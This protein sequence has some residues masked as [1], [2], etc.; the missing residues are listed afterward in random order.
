MADGAGPVPAGIGKV[1]SSS[2]GQAACLQDFVQ[3]GGRAV[4]LLCP[5]R[6]TRAAVLDR[7]L[8]DLPNYATR[9]ANP[10]A[11]PLTLHRLLFQI[12]A[13]VGDGE[14]GKVLLRC[15]HEQAGP[16]G[17]AVLAVDDAHT[18]APDALAVLAQVPSPA[19]QEQPGRLLIL[20]GHPDLM[21][22]LSQ[23]GLAALHDPARVLVLRTEGAEDGGPGPAALMGIPGGL[24]DDL[25]GDLPVP[26]P[27]PPAG[28]PAPGRVVAVEA[29]P[30][31]DP[32][33]RTP[34][35]LADRR[36][37]RL[38]ML[39][40][41]T[42]GAAVVATLV[43]SWGGPAAGPAGPPPTALPLAPASAPMLFKVPEPGPELAATP[44]PILA[45]VPIPAPMPV[46][47]PEPELAAAPEPILAPVPV[48]APV[49]DA[50]P[51]AGDAPASSPADAPAPEAQR[52]T[53]IPQS[54]AMPSG[55]DLRRDFDAFLDRAGR[56]TAS[57]SPANR[58]ALFR[59]YL[60]WRGKGPGR[61]A[62]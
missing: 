20:A 27:V 44:V 22:A 28:G 23:P 32:P 56:D 11:S 10:L 31:T 52:S 3:A 9:A 25:T 12:G 50:A 24:I 41:G 13:V 37:S 58:A 6:A 38:P 61:T 30:S 1:P 43:L 54:T 2:A 29:K 8:A 16:A 7:M 47:A 18:L 14:E 21:S 4:I 35:G 51:G 15:L 5:S 45:P 60:E 26:L 42:L 34:G 59:E 53:P 62:P 36:R 40:G 46:A 17:L 49:P 39:A 33:V 19:V 48:P 55:T 57:L